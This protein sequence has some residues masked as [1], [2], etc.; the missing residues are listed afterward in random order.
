[1]SNSFSGLA[2]A[3]LACG[4][5]LCALAVP[6]T[7]A[8]AHDAPSG[9]P[10]PYEC[11]TGIDCRPIKASQIRPGHDGYLIRTSG[12]IVVYSDARVRKSPDDDYHWC[13]NG[14]R[15]NGRTIC[16]FV[17]QQLF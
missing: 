1:M 15:D 16:L 2:K 5:A 3:A 8:M 9:W 12:E 10:Y 13:S 11:C 4:A 6:T 14:G 17:P 7:P